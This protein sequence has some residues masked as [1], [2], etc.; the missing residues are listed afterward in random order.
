M[1]KQGFGEDILTVKLLNFR[2]IDQV[3]EE[4]GKFDLFWQIWGC[5]P[6]RSTIRR[7]VFPIKWTALWSLR[8]NPQ[9]GISAAQRL[10]EVTQEE[11][12]GM[13][14]ENADEP[15]AEE[16][17][18]AV[19]RQR[20][21]RPV[22]TTT[23]LKQVIEQALSFIPEKERKEAVKK[24]CQRSFQALRIDVNSEF[25]VLYDFLEKLPQVLAPNGRAAILTFHSG[26]DRLVKKSFKQFYKEGIYSDISKNVIRPSQEECA[27]NSRR[28]IYKDALG[29]PGTGNLTEELYQA[30]HKALLFY[31]NFLHIIRIRIIIPNKQNTNPYYKA[32]R[33]MKRKTVSALRKGRNRNEANQRSHR[34]DEP[35]Y[36]PS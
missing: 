22:E 33:Q 7:E 29:N 12:Y 32:K 25:E 31:K 36:E 8:T 1:K 13:L 11:L 6:C 16:I 19:I 30:G 34:Q 10:K 18:K 35:M 21:I 9:K 3:A 15:Y 5:P 20:R 28:Q 26:E 27:R 23:D 2:N 4:A 14:L 17:S 24:S